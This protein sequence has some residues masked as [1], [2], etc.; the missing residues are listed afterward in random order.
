MV[1]NHVRNVSMK[2]YNDTLPLEIIYGPNTRNVKVAG[3]TKIL[4]NLNTLKRL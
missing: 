1:Q 4:W 3:N 2:H